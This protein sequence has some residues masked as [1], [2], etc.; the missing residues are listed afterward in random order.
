MQRKQR[1]FTLIEMAIVLVIVGLILA[2]TMPLLTERIAKEKAT[3]G[4]RGVNTLKQEIIGYAMI[5]GHLPTATYVSDNFS[6]A[7]DAWNNGVHYYPA[8]GLPAVQGSGNTINGATSTPLVLERYESST[9]S[10]DFSNM[11]F[12]LVSDGPNLD[13]QFDLQAGWTGDGASGYDG[14]LRYY[15]RGGYAD[16]AAGTDTTLLYDDVVE[17]VSLEY[18]QTK[19]DDQGGGGESPIQAVSSFEENGIASVLETG[20][21]KSNSQSQT[22]SNPIVLNEATNELE[23]GVVDEATGCTWYMDSNATIPCDNQQANAGHLA[24]GSTDIVTCYPTNWKSLHFVMRFNFLHKDY[25][26]RSPVNRFAGGWTF[27]IISANAAQNVESSAPCGTGAG[28]GMGY[29]GYANWDQPNPPTDDLYI[30]DPKFGVEVDVFKDL[31]Q[32]NVTNRQDPDPGE[33][34]SP[35]NAPSQSSY[36]WTELEE[37]NHIAIVY[38][39][40]DGS[41]NANDARHDKDNVHGYDD[42]DGGV[43]GTYTNQNPPYDASDNSTGMI[44]G[45]PDGNGTMWLEDSEDH[46]LRVELHRTNNTDS[47]GSGDVYYNMHVWIDDTPNGTFLDLSTPLVGTAVANYDVY[48]NSTTRFSVGSDKWV[49]DRNINEMMDSFRFGWTTATGSETGRNYQ[50]VHTVSI[51]KFGWNYDTF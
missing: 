30:D 10:P 14:T 16:P 28:N 37:K 18:L 46:W 47:T 50:Q 11:A 36:T 6:G 15:S 40:F 39:E 21:G 33:L 12:I 19:V 13:S 20:Q 25:Y 42:D 22:S 43:F 31:N 26:T 24:L 9:S 27:S 38:W 45:H 2:T 35:A 29:L 8:Q 41:N 7:Q 51:G 1:G 4:A 44:A 32:T 34:Y 48:T 49:G 3:E 23:L 17:Y 5:E